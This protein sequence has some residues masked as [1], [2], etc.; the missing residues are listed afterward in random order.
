[1][2]DFD[3]IASS[4]TIDW[5]ATPSDKTEYPDRRTGIAQAKESF[6]A[7]SED[8]SVEY[9]DERESAVRA[10]ART[11]IVTEK[12]SESRRLTISR[13]LIICALVSAFV[14]E[15]VHQNLDR[16]HL[17][18]RH[19]SWLAEARRAGV[20]IFFR[21]GPVEWNAMSRTL[22][23]K[24][25]VSKLRTPLLEHCFVDEPAQSPASRRRAGFAA[26]SGKGDRSPGSSF[27]IKQNLGLRSKVKNQ[28]VFCIA[29][30]KQTRT[31]TMFR[32][33]RIRAPATAL[34][35]RRLAP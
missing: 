19:P 8:E 18:G 30:R 25:V 33:K 10:T 16:L 9:S 22:V 29:N 3:A 27:Q 6:A 7:G 2:A 14:R 4:N 5:R 32:A 31:A 17:I 26:C 20:R 21:R 23:C 15:R 13:A 35:N 28:F 24:W 11:N 34:H 12:R 1:M